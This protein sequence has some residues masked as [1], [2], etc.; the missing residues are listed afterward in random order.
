MSVFVDCPGGT[1]II[2]NNNAPYCVSKLA[3]TSCTNSMTA[4]ANSKYPQSTPLVLPSTDEFDDF[5]L[6]VKG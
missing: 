1:D 3:A 5:A 4:C 6:L 2:Y